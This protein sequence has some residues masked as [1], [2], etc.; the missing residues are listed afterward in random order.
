ME[1]RLRVLEEALS[2]NLVSE[3]DT[4]EIRLA[5]MERAL[6]ASNSRVSQLI[7]KLKRASYAFATDLV[8]EDQLG[9]MSFD[10]FKFFASANQLKLL[11]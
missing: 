3:S 5:Q 7:S 6:L 2:A 1:D 4:I 11:S 10:F 8:S 9:K